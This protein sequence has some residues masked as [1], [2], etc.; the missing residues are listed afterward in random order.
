MASSV[1][2]S[3]LAAM[4]AELRV[5]RIE[6]IVVGNVASILNGAAVLTQDVDLLVRGTALNRKKLKRF[7]TAM[8]GVGPAHLS[9]LTSTERIYGSRPDRHPLRCVDRRTDLRGDPLAGP[10]RRRRA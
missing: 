5:A 10:P 9:G 8:G 3:F 6:A 2:E 1:D 7:A 4:A